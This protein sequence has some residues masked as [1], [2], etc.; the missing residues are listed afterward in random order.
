[1]RRTV[2]YNVVTMSGVTASG[3]TSPIAAPTGASARFLIAVVAAS[4]TN[5][6]LTFSCQGETLAGNYV[7]IIST[8]TFTG[9][10]SA[11]IEIDKLPQIYRIA[12]EVGGTSPSFSFDVDVVYELVEA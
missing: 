7:T 2:Q 3:S 8:A 12:W 1:M 6:T 10:G 11:S 4:G 5:P 9:P